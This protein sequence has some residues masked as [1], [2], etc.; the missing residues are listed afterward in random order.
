MPWRRPVHVCYRAVPP[1]SYCFSSSTRTMS[2]CLKF[3]HYLFLVDF[4]M[5]KALIIICSCSAYV[6]TTKKLKYVEICAFSPETK[7]RTVRSEH[8]PLTMLKIAIFQQQYYPENDTKWRTNKHQHP[9]TKIH[10]HLD[11]SDFTYL[12]RFCHSIL[13]TDLSDFVK[14]FQF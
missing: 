5:T 13:N 2:I 9:T 8:R 7:L 14:G 11:D 1:Q 3:Q 6:Q 12:T 10:S 4:S